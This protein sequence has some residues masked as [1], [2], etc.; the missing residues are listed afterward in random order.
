MVLVTKA[1]R[2]FCGTASNPSSSRFANL[3]RGAVIAAALVQSP[4]AHA[5]T[6]GPTVAG[7]PVFPADNIWNTRVDKLPIDPRSAQYIASIGASDSLKADFG[8]GL[9]EGAPIGIPYVIVPMN[10][11]K[12]TI[13]FR[14][15]ESEPAVPDESDAGPYPIPRNAPIEGG[16]KSR[17]DR[18][19][20]VA[21][22]GSCTLFE[23][24]KAVPNSDGTWNAV[25]AA[26]F[27]LEGHELRIDGRTSADAAGLPIFPGLV[28][29]E[30]VAIG[31]IRHALRFTAKRSRK[32]YIWPARHFASEETDETLPPLGQRF[33]LRSN[34]D[35]SRYSKSNQVILRA[36][37]TYGMFLADN[38]SP[39]FLSGAPHDA[40]SNDD[41]S[42]L[43]KV[44]GSDFEA[45]DHSSL[46]RDEDSGQVRER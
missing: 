14:D 10:Q 2:Q 23:L 15:F 40:W 27:D 46:M 22:Q 35:I 37:Q 16:L 38:G 43:R 32:A 45:V 20:I 19:V 26:R 13:H 11:P 4:V 9:Y 6:A 33:R 30:E 8:A 21:Q 41:L 7:C 5:Q 39:W 36:L 28:R 42:A 17:D 25:G 34:F 29:Q 18:H 3:M 31:E 44:K 24:Y 1:G 12:V